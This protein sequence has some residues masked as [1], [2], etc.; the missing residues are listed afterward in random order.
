MKLGR[1]IDQRSPNL[2]RVAEENQM[3]VDTLILLALGGTLK[4]S[5]V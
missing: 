2:S 3:I 1:P 4:M 5:T